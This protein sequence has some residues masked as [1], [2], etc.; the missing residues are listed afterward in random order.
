[1]KAELI[2]ADYIFFLDELELFQ[3]NPYRQLGGAAEL[4]DLK[5]KTWTQ[6]NAA[7]GEDVER[8]E[9]ADVPLS[10]KNK[11][12]AVGRNFPNDHAYPALIGTVA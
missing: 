3:L 4:A 12:F 8:L 11:W 5:V 7:I 6:V 10:Q 9:R 2:K 1:M